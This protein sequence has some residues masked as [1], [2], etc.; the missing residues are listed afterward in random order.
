MSDPG[1]ELPQCHPGGTDEVGA[2]LKAIYSWNYIRNY[3]RNYAREIDR[4]TFTETFSMGGIPIRDTAFWKGLPLETRWNV[5]RCSAAFMLSNFSHGE[6]G[7][8]WVAGQMVSAVPHLEGKFHAATQ[9]LDEARHTGY[10]IKYLTHVVPGLSLAEKR[11]LQ[12]FAFECTRALMASRAGL[13]MRD[14]LMQVWAD[15]DVDPADVIASLEKERDVIAG[16]VWQTGGRYGPVRGFIIPT[17]RSLGLYDA[18]TAEPFKEMWTAGQGA[19]AAERY[20]NADAELPEDLEQR[21]NRG[22]EAL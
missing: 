3:V 9:A 22:Y 6:R 12:D 4:E 18:R 17:L 10:G 21:V 15:C 19:R 1:E 5:S 7:A 13:T 14:R 16:A 2:A 20:A 8:L 11:A